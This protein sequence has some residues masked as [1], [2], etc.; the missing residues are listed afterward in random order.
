M[1]KQ[2]STIIITASAAVLAMTACKNSPYPGYEE[3]D[4]NVYVKYY[5]HDESGVKPKE[6]DLVRITLVIMNEKDSILR[7]SRDDSKY[8][9]PGVK[10]YEFPLPKPQFK[11]SFED[12]LTLLSVGDSA[13]FLINVDT[14]FKGQP[15]P[16]FLKKGS[17]LKYEV[18]LQKITDKSEVEKEQ[19]K[20]ME[21]Q[22][23]MLELRKNEEPKALAKYIEDNKITVKPTQSGLYYIETKKGNGPKAKDGDNV[24]VNYTG[25]LLSG[26]IFDTSDKDAAKA[27]GIFDERRPYEPIPITLGTHGVIP[28]WEEALLL[29]SAGTKAKVIIPSNLGYDKMGNGPIPPYAPLVFEMELVKIEPKK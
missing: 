25:S 28:G 21:E 23:V 16:P 10:Y 6:G 19:K 18:K 1:K 13:S 27:A 5:T 11:G 14:M 3:T 8:N 2:F 15:L 20:K 12:G 22:N 9:S 24:L 4:K 7:D 29:M 26:G 17:M